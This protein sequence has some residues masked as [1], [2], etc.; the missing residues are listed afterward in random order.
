MYAYG[1]FLLQKIAVGG[2]EPVRL[3][4]EVA[5]KFYRLQKISESSIVLRD[6]RPG[7]LK[8]PTVVGTGGHGEEHIELS[9][10][11]DLLNDKFGTDFAPADQ[12]FFDAVEEDAVKDE[13]VRQAAEANSHDNFGYVFDRKLES[14]FIDRIEQNADIFDRL[15]TDN[16]LNRVVTDWMRRRVYDRVRNA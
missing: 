4:D 3:D 2:T 5:L 15:M 7:E 9:Q 8:G 14:L 13:E 6:G 12:L 10:L 11:I 16:D 1:R